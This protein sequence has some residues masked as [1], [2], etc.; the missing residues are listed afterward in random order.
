M[1]GPNLCHLYRTGLCI[2]RGISR[3][4]LAQQFRS[5]PTTIL[6]TFRA[7]S[8]STSVPS[9]MKAV[10]FHKTGGPE[11]IVFEDI[12][13]PK[14]KPEELLIKVEWAGVN[15]IDNYFRGG[16]YATE[17][18]FTFGQEASGTI[19]Q[20]PTSKTVLEDPEY[21]AK[22]FKV[23]DRVVTSEPKTFAEYSVARWSHVVS[24]PS[25]IDPKTGGACITQGLTALTIM[26]E[27]YAVKKGDWILVH[28]VAGGLGLQ[29]AQIGHA[30]GAHVIGTT[31]TAEKAALAKKHGAEHVILRNDSNVVQEV[32]RLTNGEG[33]KAVFDGVGKD[34]WE[35]NFDLIARKGTI[36]T[37]GNA[38]GAVPPFN[39]LK[40]SAKN[41]K[42][43]RPR[44]GAYVQTA[45]EFTAYATEYLSLLSSGQVRV[46]IHKEYP[47]SA[48]GVRQSQADITGGGTT[49][50][51]LINVAGSASK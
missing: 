38:S 8:T 7:M 41:I 14:P 26:R 33:V 46:N 25:S 32:Q 6:P 22:G 43:V 51:L 19:V 21:S 27:S 39:V 48:E 3:R 29:F 9:S 42:V 44:M 30:L 49:G 5:S 4:G 12:D 18:P 13:T 34:T 47:F 24:L 16:L 10:R 37:C 35:G 28:A 11:V 36:V 15:F 45:A 40:L 50:K 23:G 2:S 1:T 17:L 31:S 20:L